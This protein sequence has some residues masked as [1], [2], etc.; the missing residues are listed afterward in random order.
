MNERT[1]GFIIAG[2][3]LILMG[4]CVVFFLG[5]DRTAPVITIEPVSYVYE[6]DLPENILYQGIT[7][8]DTEDG[9]VTAKVVIEKVVTDREKGKAIIT[10]GVSDSYGNVSKATRTL[11]MPV[12][13]RIQFPGAGEAGSTNVTEAVATNTEEEAETTETAQETETEETVDA[14]AV[15]EVE[16]NEEAAEESVENIADENTEENATEENTEESENTENEEE[17][18]TTGGNVTVVGSNNRRN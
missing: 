9:D 4:V 10:Y 16:E 13:T 17:G 5:K 1:L 7:A 6:E 15:E 11:D 18:T 14:E 2:L 12:L 8:L 3:N